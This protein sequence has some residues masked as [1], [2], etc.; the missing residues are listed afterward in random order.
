MCADQEKIQFEEGSVLSILR[1]LEPKEA[2][3]SQRCLKSI[4]KLAVNFRT[5]L[6]E[7]ELDE[8]KDQCRDLLYCKE[9]LKGTSDKATAFWCELQSVKDE[10]GRRKFV[11]LSKFMCCLLALPHSSA[12]VERAFSQMNFMKTKQTNKLQVSTVANRLLAV[13]AIARQATSCM[14]W[15]P[16][17]TLIRYVK[18][19]PCY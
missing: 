4:A 11:L 16:S 15:K 5:I 18:T 10:I 8:L 19:G 1:I 6:K 2:L 17:S 13:Q 3:S 14:N 12:C 7:E 9:S